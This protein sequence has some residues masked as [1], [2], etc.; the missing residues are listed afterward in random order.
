MDISFSLSKEKL[1][2]EEISTDFFFFF[3]FF[4]FFAKKNKTDKTEKGRRREDF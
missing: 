3:L 4:C 1:E 2:R